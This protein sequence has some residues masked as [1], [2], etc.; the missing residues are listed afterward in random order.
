MDLI[1]FGVTFFPNGIPVYCAYIIP[2]VSDGTAAKRNAPMR[3]PRVYP[4][5]IHGSYPKIDT[6]RREYV[7]RTVKNTTG[8]VEIIP[9]I[10]LDKMIQ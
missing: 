2:P 6:T 4:A 8:R 3:T 1:I 10:K 7:G 5:N 9:A